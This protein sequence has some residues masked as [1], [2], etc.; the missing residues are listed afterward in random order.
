[1]AAIIFYS[2]CS[3]DSSTESVNSAPEIQKISANPSAIKVSGTISL[4]CEATDNDGDELTCT[5]SL[6]KGTFTDGSSGTSVNWKAPG[7]VGTYK[8]GVIISDGELSDEGEI[9]LIV[10]LNPCPETP[11]VNYGNKK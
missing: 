5:W 1:M 9:E 10:S 4:S 6:D 2:G 7:E 11:I 3:D 8:V